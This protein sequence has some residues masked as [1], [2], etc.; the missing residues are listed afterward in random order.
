MHELLQ[1]RYQ[2][3]NADGNWVVVEELHGF[4]GVDFK[5]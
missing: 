3:T 4:L 1:G 5:N 2:D